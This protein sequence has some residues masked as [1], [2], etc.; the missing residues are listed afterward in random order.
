MSEV[1]SSLRILMISPEV[2]PF[3]KTGGLADVVGSLPVALHQLGCD[4]ALAMP[5]Y[6]QVVAE[7]LG[8]EL[9]LEHLPV[10]LGSQV[11]PAEVWQ[12]KLRERIPVFFI[13][14]DELF[15]RTY[16]YG[17]P[18]GDYFDNA[19]RFA[20]FC[21]AV[22]ALCPALSYRPHIVH[23]HD[24]QT[25]LVPA[26][27]RLVHGGDP[28]WI[29]TASMFTVHNIA[30]QGQFAADLF[31]V[32][33]LPGHFFAVG[34]MEFWGGINYMKA[35]IICADV[36]TTVSPRYS[37]EIRIPPAG[38]GLEGVL[39]AQ[40]H[41]L[42]GIV[43]GA[44]YGEWNPETDSLI[45]ARYSAKN[46]AGKKRCKRDLLAAV[47]LPLGLMDRPVLGMVSRLTDQKGLDL[48]AAAAERLVAKDLGLIILGTGEEKYHR[49]FSELA[50]RHPENVAVRLGFDNE[51]AHKIEAGVDI[52][53]MPSQFEP[54][55]LNQMYSLRYGTVPI[56]HATGGLYDTVKPF[57]PEGGEGVGFRFTRY[58]PEALWQAIEAAIA[59]FNRPSLWQKIMRNGMAMDF[60]WEKSAR[61]YLALYEK[62]VAGRRRPPA[63]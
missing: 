44:D 57:D 15:D 31:P 36:I 20:Y 3:A 60:S 35:G 43:N 10:P 16:L 6:R 12:G 11:V 23:C 45:V 53:L 25:G 30:Y 1:A 5:F 56:V 13:R 39:Q 62:A 48:I 59:M 41:K 32:T 63:R 49:L 40:G 54:C 22:M 24:W 61:L 9:I 34:G 26:Y 19:Q 46:F 2:V 7:N 33:G 51:L 58:E 21:Q 55:G 29:E 4:V 50:R 17:T 8:G 38:R 27:L 28:F 47:G 52:F 18:R 14:R 37:E 42:H